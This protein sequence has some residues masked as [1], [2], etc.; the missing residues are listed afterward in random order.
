[1]LVRFPTKG[2]FGRRASGAFTRLLLRLLCVRLR[3][4]CYCWYLRVTVSH[5]LDP[6]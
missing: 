6:C 2:N 3:R 4:M 5:E 1:M